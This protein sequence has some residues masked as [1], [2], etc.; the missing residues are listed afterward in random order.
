M[1]DPHP[2]PRPFVAPIG[3]ADKPA[4]AG[5]RSLGVIAVP[6]GGDGRIVVSN[7]A[8]LAKAAAL[9]HLAEALHQSIGELRQIIDRGYEIESRAEYVPSATRDANR[10]LDSAA[11]TLDSAAA[12]A[13]NIRS[14]ILRAQEEYTE[15]ELVSKRVMHFID[16]QVAWAVGA[17]VLANAVPIALGAIN[18]ATVVVGEGLL[19]GI[20]PGK[21]GSAAEDFLKSNPRILTNPR[22]VGMIR[23][24][25]SDIDGFD[26]GFAGVPLPIADGAELGGRTG[27]RS[28]AGIVLDYANA[29]GLFR[30]TPVVVRRTTSFDYDTPPRS[31]F[32]RSINFPDPHEDANGEQIR[33]DKYVVPGQPDRFD[34]YIAGTVTFDPRTGA[35]PFDGTSDLRGVAGLPTAS[36]IA[37][38]QAMAK[39][40]VTAST[41]VVLNGYSQGGLIAS[42]IAASGNYDV[43]GVLTFGAP[44]AQV[45]IPASI[46]V[47]SVRNTEDLVPAT[48][49]YDV[50]PN[51]V[52]VQ[53]SAFAD[54]PIPNDWAVPAHR[55]AY[56]QQTAAV[57]D[58]ASS[59]EVLKVTKVLDSFGE[60]AKNIESSL[61]VA[62]RTDGSSTIPPLVPT[63]ASS[64]PAREAV[65]G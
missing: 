34:V 41:P 3:I 5:V 56:Y 21:L 23:E 30:E 62:T 44:S 20:P 39:A 50:N 17:F 42:V 61:W 24:L 52:I 28:S 16:E 45:H 60:G 27:V 33:I 54:Q 35:E 63:P 11:Q 40:G 7:D 65:A 58:T 6:P 22:A 9:G 19:A 26:A 37:V 46:P 13:A 10:S 18:A 47:L 53:R 59:P 36:T 25:A 43:K 2:D 4:P 15:A 51:A 38:E 14:G 29:F 12:H 8:M 1:A 32:D 49:G 48:S 64:L 55:L 31:V 57:V